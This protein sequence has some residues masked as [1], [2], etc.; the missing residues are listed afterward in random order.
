[1][2]CLAGGGLLQ[3][4]EGRDPSDP[5]GDLEPAPQRVWV[6]MGGDSAE[7]QSS[8]AS[9]LTAFLHLRTQA[10]VRVRAHRRRRSL[11]RTSLLALSAR[12][13]C[14]FRG[15]GRPWAVQGLYRMGMPIRHSLGYE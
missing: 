9:G 12:E 15:C 10:D 8:L 1:M 6:L 14:C 11:R 2:E 7:M 13:F 3:E 4:L 5:G